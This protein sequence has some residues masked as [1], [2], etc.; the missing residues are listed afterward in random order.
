MPLLVA[1]TS[2]ARR[3]RDRRESLA[4][5]SFLL[6]LAAGAVYFAG[7]L[8]WTSAV[9]RTYGDLS[10]PLSIVATGAL[11]A[12]MALYPALFALIVARLVGSM[13]PVALL[14]SPAVWVAAELGRTH[15]LSGFPWVLLGYSQ[16]Q[17]VPVAQLA[18]V[19]G[20]HGLSGLVA[21]VNASLAHLALARG[22]G[23]VVVAGGAVI[24]TLGVTLWGSVRVGDGSLMRQ[25]RPLRVALLQG[26]VPQ[27]K[28]W[29]PAHAES[30]LRTYVAMTRQA[31][32]QRAALIIWPESA[33]PFY[34]EED[35]IGGET[36]R[37][38]A[39]D[40]R[41]HLLIGSDQ[42]ER[43]S[44]PRYYNAAFLVEPDGRTAA[45]YRKVHLVPFG[46][47][48]PLKR[49]LF[50]IQ[51]LVDAVS[52]FSPGA[53]AVMLPV[54]PHKA[55]TAICY[56]VVYPQLIRRAV[57]LGSELLTTITNDAWYGNSS[58]PYQHFWQA[59]MRAIE[60][61]RF[62][63]RAANTGISGIVDPYGRVVV[64]SRLF[65]PAVLVG[66]VRFLDGRTIY[67]RTGD[68]FAYLCV[69]VTIV[70]LIAAIKGSRIPNP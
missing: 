6:G 24:L 36:I 7:T 60:Q 52:D 26:N 10:L 53:D 46:E 15:L 25:G 32:S 39:R 50:F 13:G 64:Q 19:L 69:G 16:V 63:A 47:Y 42:L 4:R 22:R 12:Y 5:R 30:I 45:V 21:L 38:L 14:L 44:P 8:Y 62:L 65:E 58:A 41:A 11:V 61:G 17:V 1:L 34:Y 59:A 23:P 57:L 35:P 51:P 49:V 18:S 56:E 37:R 3:A 28:K 2:A 66:D 40:T 29:D 27:E 9:V 20:V 43:T 68:L 70:A 31:A 33:T 48:V 67:A 55:S 54:G